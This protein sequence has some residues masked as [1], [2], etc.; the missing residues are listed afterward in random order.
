[1]CPG[2]E[3]R[4]IINGREPLIPKDGGE[5]CHEDTMRA[6]AHQQ[7]GD[8]GGFSIQAFLQRH[9]PPDGFLRTLPLTEVSLSYSFLFS[10]LLSK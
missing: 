6:R 8:G 7:L 5:D 2:T 9:L 10:F 1:M 3:S 4:G